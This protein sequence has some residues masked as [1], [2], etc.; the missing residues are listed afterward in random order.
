V[1]WGTTSPWAQST[2]GAESLD[3]SINGDK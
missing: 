2:P 1:I 3:I